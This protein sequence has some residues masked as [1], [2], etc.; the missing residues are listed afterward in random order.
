MILFF[1][2]RNNNTTESELSLASKKIPVKLDYLKIIPIAMIAGF[3]FGILGVGGGFL[4]VPLLVLLFDLPLK[5]AIGT[6]LLIVLCNA[7]LGIAGKLLSIR[8][9]LFIGLSVAIGAIAGSRIGTYLNRKTS[10]K[11]IRIIFIT[12]LTIIIVRVGWDLY[13]NFRM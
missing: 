12:L 4:Y 6:S 3:A 13:L 10:P 8:F 7:I 9:D 5:I 1:I 2:K 11:L